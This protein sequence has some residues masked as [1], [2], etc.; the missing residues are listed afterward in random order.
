MGWPLVVAI[1]GN[2]KRAADRIEYKEL[3]SPTRHP[4]TVM[5]HLAVASHEKR[6]Y[7]FA[8]DVLRAYPCVDS[9]EHG[10]P[11]GFTRLTGKPAK[12][13]C[14]EEPENI[15]FTHTGSLFL[16]VCVEDMCIE[17]ASGKVFSFLRNLVMPY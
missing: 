1:V 9:S 7:I 5:A 11:K 6:R 8:A 10:M 12:L 4:R 2:G 15:E 13:V 17:E 14:E 16:W 3:L